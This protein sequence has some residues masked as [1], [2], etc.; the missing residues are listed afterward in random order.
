MGDNEISDDDNRSKKVWLLLAYMI[1]C[2]DRAISQDDIINLLWGDEESSTNPINALKTMLHR[3]R[4]MLDG[5]EPGAG[6]ALILRRDGSYAWNPNAQFTFDAEAFDV[7]CAAGAAAD[8]DDVR[9]EKY[10]RALSVY[11]GD[12][13]PKLISEPWVVPINA[14]YHDLYMRTVCS[15]AEMLEA[16]GRYGDVVEIC[17]R[18]VIIEPYS[19]EMYLHYLQAMLTV[20][21]NRGVV[22]VYQDMSEL[23]FSNFGVMPSPELTAIFRKA[24]SMVNDKEVSMGIVREQLMEPDFGVGALFCDYDLFKVIYHAQA[25]SIVRSGDAVHIGLITVS[26]QDR[27]ELSKQS[28]DVCMENLRVTIC[29]CLRKGDV[30]SR[31]SVSQYVILLPQANYENSCMVCERVVKAFNRQYPHSPAELRFSVQPLEPIL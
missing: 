19:E 4:T 6:H 20:G 12:F 2:R 15:S 31:C 27:K 10:L 26:G 25:R 21:D 3:L 23:M 18:A 22:D 28:L 30:A 14:Y 8:S 24:E 9:L 1:C 16:A 11:S 17:R 13:L 7:L 5:L 29:T